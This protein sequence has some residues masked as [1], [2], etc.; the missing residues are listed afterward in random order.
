MPVIGPMNSKED[1]ARMAN[2]EYTPNF[3]G[4]DFLGISLQFYWEKISLYITQN[5]LLIM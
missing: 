1:L 4:P 5:I 2:G 3:I